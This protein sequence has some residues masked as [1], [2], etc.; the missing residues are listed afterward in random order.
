MP[1]A[2][3]PSPASLRG[4]GR[5]AP[6]PSGD[7][8]IGNLRTAMLAWL[9]ARSTGRRFMIRIENLDR[10]R[11]A[12]TAADQLEDLATLGIEWDEPPIFQTD[13]IPEYEAVLQRLIS[14]GLVYECYCS[15]ADIQAAPTA[16]HHPPG[17]Y[18]GTCRNLEENDRHIR[19]ESILPRKPALRIKLRTQASSMTFTDQ[20][21]GNVT[22]GIDDLVVRRGDGTF[23]YNFVSVIDDAAFGVDQVVRGDDLLLSTPR[24]IVLGQLLGYPTPTYLHVPLV[25]TQTGKR[26][27][28]RDGAVTLRQLRERGVS[29]NELRSFIGASL[30]LNDPAERIS[31]VE[32]LQ[33]FDIS[34][35]PHEPWRISDEVLEDSRLQIPRQHD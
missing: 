18:P 22:G 1:G 8:H 2:T 32:M 14:D 16:P 24:Q 9:A 25:L 29:A 17:T 26:L 13:R 30:G 33:R 6:S 35:L 27:A 5:Y 23:A 10:D 12:G 3:Q 34:T 7:L 21:R 19:R 28:K 11:D 20:Q 31:A 15:R 4:A